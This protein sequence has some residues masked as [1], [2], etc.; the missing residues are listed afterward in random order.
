MSYPNGPAPASHRQ[1]GAPNESASKRTA[2]VVHTIAD[3][4]AGFLVLWIVLSLLE[5]NQANVFVQFVQ[6]MANWLAGWSQ[7][8]FTME[9]EH[10]RLVLNY[11]LPAVLYLV[12]GHGIAARLRRA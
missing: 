1:S 7:D 3:I 8:I 9:N 4:A 2:L 12:V 5:A 6:D 10:I 11:G